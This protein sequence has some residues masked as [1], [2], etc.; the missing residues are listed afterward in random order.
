MGRT[1]NN[2]RRKKGAVGGNKDSKSRAPRPRAP[3]RSILLKTTIRTRIGL[4]IRFPGTMKI[5]LELCCYIRMLAV[6]MLSLKRA[7]LRWHLSIIQ[8]HSTSHSTSFN[9]PFNIPINLKGFHCFLFKTV[10]F[11]PGLASQIILLLI[12]YYEEVRPGTSATKVKLN[13]EIL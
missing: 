13:C 5:M 2:G 1:K 8:H 10:R 9:I 11:C 6:V 4:T 7:L 3:Q 12:N